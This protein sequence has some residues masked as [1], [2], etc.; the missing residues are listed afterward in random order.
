MT[1]KIISLCVTLMI[2]CQL[3]ADLITIT[4]NF[5]TF[6]ALGE[7]GKCS[8]TDMKNMR[9]VVDTDSGKGKMLGN[10]GSTDVVVVEGE[11][12]ISFIQVS[13]VV[14]TTT[15]QLSTLKAVHSRN[16]VMLGEFM[17][18]QYYGKATSIE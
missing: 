15:V 2:C 14:T 7:T 16:V 10:A 18:A 4:C 12:T 1:K 13:P 11:D 6:S 9:Y 8:P 3:Q 17:P 5:Y